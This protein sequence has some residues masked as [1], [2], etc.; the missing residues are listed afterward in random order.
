MIVNAA[1][2]TAWLWAWAWNYAWWAQSYYDACNRAYL[3][4]LGVS[5]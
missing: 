4:A 3:R 1:T 2:Y 5:V